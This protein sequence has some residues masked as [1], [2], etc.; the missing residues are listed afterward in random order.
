[1][2][3]N[4]AAAAGSGSFAMLKKCDTPGIGPYQDIKTSR[5]NR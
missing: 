3:A 1:M 4:K 5:V 2:A